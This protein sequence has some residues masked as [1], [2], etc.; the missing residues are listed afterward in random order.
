MQKQHTKATPTNALKILDRITGDDPAL[1]AL[2][3]EE[4]L[5]AHVARMIYEAR[6]QAGLT[7]QELARLV[8]TKQPLIARLEDADHNG[9]SL[10]MLQR[11]A[12][13]LHQRLEVHLV[14]DAQLEVSRGGSPRNGEVYAV[15]R[16]GVGRFVARRG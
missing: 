8:G 6:T 5:H 4:T 10:S 1:R 13:A 12:T 16:D 15:W 11:I 3:E 7:Q 2:I 14:P 9:H